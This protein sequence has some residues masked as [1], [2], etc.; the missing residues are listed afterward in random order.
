LKTLLAVGLAVGLAFAA[1]GGNDKAAA[2]P[3]PAD[4][5]QYAAAMDGWW[6]EV[7]RGTVPT[8]P[9][10]YSSKLDSTRIQEA[11]SRPKERALPKVVAPPAAQTNH[12]LLMT[13]V[14]GWAVADGRIWRPSITA[15]LAAAFCRPL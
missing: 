10:L 9:F 11:W 6:R 15:G 3:P 12:E 5:Q 13:T 7:A 14:F 2:P 1:C 8:M 4:V